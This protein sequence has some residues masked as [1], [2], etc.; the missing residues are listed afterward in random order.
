MRKHLCLL[1]VRSPFGTV[2]GI[3]TGSL[4]IFHRHET[5][6][7]LLATI[8]LEHDDNHVFDCSRCVIV[9]KKKFE[10]SQISHNPI[11]FVRNEREE[12][13]RRDRR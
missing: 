9:T 3:V 6:S 12:E 8:L 7:M 5:I 2:T 1:R 4:M 10:Q 13:R 11:A